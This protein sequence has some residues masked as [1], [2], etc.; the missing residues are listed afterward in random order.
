MK[1]N[2]TDKTDM[3]GNGNYAVDFPGFCCRQRYT[4]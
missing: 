3:N 1:K 4:R 2:E